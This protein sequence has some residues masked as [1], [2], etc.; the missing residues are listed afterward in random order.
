[1][2]YLNDYLGMVSLVALFLAGL[3][4]AYLFRDYLHS[5]FQE[6]AILM[7]LGAAR[8]STYLLLLSQILILG[9][10]AVIVSCLRVSSVVTDSTSSCLRFSSA[11]LSTR[12]ALDQSRGGHG[13]RNH[14]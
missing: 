12:N 8:R 14:W 3:G 1:L 13:V 6:I 9:G 7:S 11:W 4:A 2:G 10:M 5:R